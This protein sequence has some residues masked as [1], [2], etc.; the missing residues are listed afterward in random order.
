[1]G[2]RTTNKVSSSHTVSGLDR[3]NAAALA[4]LRTGFIYVQ[5]GEGREI[6]GSR[7]TLS[8]LQSVEEYRDLWFALERQAG[9]GCMVQ[10]S[11]EPH[12]NY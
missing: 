10:H 3:A 1:M 7:R 2:R 12:A 5:D 6:P 8:D 4:K 11:E 9:E